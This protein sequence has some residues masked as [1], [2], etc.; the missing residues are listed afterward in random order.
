M[1]T[2]TQAIRAY[3]FKLGLEPEIADIYLALHAY[4]PQSISALARNSGVERTR[5][6]RLMDAIQMSGLVEIET[7]NKYNTFR[8]APITNLQILI[9]KKEQEVRDLQTELHELHRSL[10]HSTLS[11]PVTRVQFYQGID[12]IKQMLW[13]QTKSNSENL[14]IL[15]EN[16]QYRVKLA[17]FERWVAACN[18]K[19][20]EF[21]GIIGDHFIETQQQWYSE[22]ANERLNVWRSGYVANSIFPITHSTVIYDNTTT[23]YNWKDGEV[24]GLEIVNQQIA[25]TQRRLFEMLWALS[26][27]V[28]DLEGLQ[29]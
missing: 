27:E 14:A 2:D 17:F 28:N 23:Y 18:K 4:G 16:M 6:Y 12:G 1:A 13:N 29:R 26:T 21:R 11:S 7:H 19:G 25:E 5:I 24:F 10:E 20:L 9:A 8:A 15:Y 3:F 22:H